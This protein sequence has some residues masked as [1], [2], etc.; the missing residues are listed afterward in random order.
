MFIGIDCFCD[1]EIRSMILSSSIKGKCDITGKENVFIY[2]TESC[3]TSL[4]DYLSELIDVYT[5]E[6]ELKSFPKEKLAAVE[7]VL[8]REVPLL[9]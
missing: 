1:D 2:D 3:D 9:L 8:K 6:S 5:P 7:D 4:S